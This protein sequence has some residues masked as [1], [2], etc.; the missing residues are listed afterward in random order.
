MA[1]SMPMPLSE[2]VIKVSFSF[3]SAITLIFPL[4]GVNFMALD[5]R[6]LKMV[7]V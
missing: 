5:I 4:G 2:T 6:F 7:L 1:G 3:F